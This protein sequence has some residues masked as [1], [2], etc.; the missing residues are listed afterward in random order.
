LEK[1]KIILTAFILVFAFGLTVFL[2]VDA[3]ATDSVSGWLWGGSDTNVGW[4]SAN[5]TNTGGAASYGLNIPATDGNLSGYAWSEN[6]G[7]I[8]FNPGDVVG[9]P[10]GTCSARR[11][12]NALQGWARIVGIKTE[13]TFGNSGGWQGWVKL[14][15]AN[16][17]VSINTVTSALSGYAWSDELG[18]IDFS[19]ASIAPAPISCGNGIQEGAEQCDSG[20]NNGNCPQ[21]CSSTCTNNVCPPPVVCGNGIIDGTDIC[22]NGSANNGSCPLTC[23]ATCTKNTCSA[24]FSDRNWKEVAP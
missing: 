17:G 16:Y 13:L 15:G 11:V 4:I 1:K 19:R 22:D 8:S 6:I 12:G 7:W 14:S 21:S 10:S 3:A 20:V 24:A 18:W 2:R 9:C 5:N 23:S